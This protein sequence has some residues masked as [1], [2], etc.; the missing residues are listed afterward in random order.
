L[1][2]ADPG[3]HVIRRVSTT[4]GAVTVFAGQLGMLGSTG[5]GLVATGARLNRPS[6]VAVNTSGDV[7]IADTNNHRVRRVS[8]STIATVVSQG[9]PRSGFEGDGRPANAARLNSPWAVYVDSGDNLYVND[10]GNNRIRRVNAADNI[11]NT[12]I[13]NG[14]I[15][16][17]GDGGPATQAK[18]SLPGTMA[19][20]PGTL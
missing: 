17:G 6:G 10:R 4:G 3:N 18:L 19:V 8:N 12:I 20:P 1:Y 16:L 5:D 14:D 2:I 13:G 11:I 7:F 9:L 15:G